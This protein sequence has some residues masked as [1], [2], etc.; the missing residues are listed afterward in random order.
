MD[1][2]TLEVLLVLSEELHFRRAA[3]RLG[4]NQSSVSDHVRKLETR[5]QRTLFDRTSRRVVLTE[6]GEI[7]AHRVRDP[8]QA[9][10]AAIQD[11][12]RDAPF[13]KETLKV[14]FMGG[15]FYELHEPLVNY[16]KDAHPEIALE[17]VEVHYD[18]QFLAILQGEVDVGFCRLPIGLPGLEAGPIVMSDPRVVCV[19]ASHRLADRD[20]IDAEE[21]RGE[22][23]LR[24]PA[25]R[26]G[27][28]WAEY[29]FP[30][31]TPEGHRLQAGPTVR[32]VREGIAAVVAGSGIFLLTKRAANYYATPR[33][34]YIEVNLPPIQSALVWR[35]DGYKR[36][37]ALLSQGL[38][39]VASN[40][41][42][43]NT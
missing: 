1:I 3:E 26:T 22:T 40:G 17:F 43:G 38:I 33:I 42:R 9:I 35:Q 25:S 29:H 34:R 18:N 16:F 15:G 2:R 20:H 21:L 12:Q 39:K 11:A 10:K 24:A 6:A 14:G 28:K 19:N 37:I 13:I 7:L 31:T 8:V 23:M 4:M 5:L 32:T 30:L 41:A 27:T 36:P